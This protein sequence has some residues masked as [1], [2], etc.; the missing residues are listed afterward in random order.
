VMYQQT[1]YL[2]ARE[3][4]ERERLS[5]DMVRRAL[6]NGVLKGHHVGGR[7]DWR[8][9]DSDCADWIARGAPTK[10]EKEAEA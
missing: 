5:L 8:I 6:N 2:T 1:S 4:A 7:G 9:A 10:A 3:V